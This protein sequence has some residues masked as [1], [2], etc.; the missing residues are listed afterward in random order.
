MHIFPDFA[1]EVAKKQAAFAVARQL[2]RNIKDD[3]FGLRYPAT[4]WIMFEDEEHFFTDPEL[5]VSY[6]YVSNY[7]SS[8]AK[9]SC[10]NIYIVRYN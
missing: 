5:A 10:N 3:K 8:G 6:N 7:S 9:Y 4:F 1:P 2:L